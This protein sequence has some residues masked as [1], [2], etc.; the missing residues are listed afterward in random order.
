MG[1]KSVLKLLDNIKYAQIMKLINKTLLFAFLI[2]GTFL[3]AEGPPMPPPGGGGGGGGGTVPG[4]PAS[5]IDMYVYV[6]G[7]V[8]ILFIVYY[9]RRSQKKLI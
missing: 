5:P 3:R 6:L 1:K 8:A 7:L 9:S 4:T 2:I